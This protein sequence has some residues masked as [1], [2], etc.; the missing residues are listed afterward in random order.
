MG[1]D[2][3]RRA[4][5]RG[6]DKGEERAEGRGGGEAKVTLVPVISACKTW[7]S[8]VITFSTQRRQREPIQALLLC[9]PAAQS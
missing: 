2:K 8:M 1:S 3:K 9:T 7:L 5:K 4:G 6:R